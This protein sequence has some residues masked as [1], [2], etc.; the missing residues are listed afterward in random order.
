ML[1]YNKYKQDIASGKLNAIKYIFIAIFFFSGLSAHGSEAKKI[2]AFGDSLIAGYGLGPAEGFTV[3]LEHKLNA[4][5]L[6]SSV[7]NAGVSGDTT[8][9]GFARLEWVLASYTDIDLVILTLGGNDALRGINPDLTRRNMDKMLA[10]LTNHNIPTLIAGMMAPPNLGPRYVNK[11]NSI[12]P[13]MAK[14]YNL[15]LYPFFLDGVAGIIDLN[16]RDRI[17]PNQSGVDIITD[18]ISPVIINLLKNSEIQN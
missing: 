5:G 3:I 17:H 6:P 2:L 12:Y 1:Y 16:Q 11:F 7:I 8:S 4:K 18:K 13:D 14:K 10:I 15:P 9:G